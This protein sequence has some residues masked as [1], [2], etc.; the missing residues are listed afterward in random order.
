MPLLILVLY[1]VVEVAA[2]VLVASWIGIGWTLLALLG[3]SLLGA[4]LL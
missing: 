1:V 2:A 3:L 4:V